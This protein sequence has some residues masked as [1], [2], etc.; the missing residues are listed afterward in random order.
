MVYIHDSDDERNSKNFRYVKIA[1]YLGM[2][3]KDCRTQYNTLD[4]KTRKEFDHF[5]DEIRSEETCK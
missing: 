5:I 4:D 3:W 2:D 1:H